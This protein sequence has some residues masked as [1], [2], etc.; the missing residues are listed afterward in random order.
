ME[1]IA[2]QLLDLDMSRVHGML[3]L[4]SR[5]DEWN[6]SVWPALHCFPFKL[7]NNNNNNLN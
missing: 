1:T 6:S 3:D 4:S 5:L 7:N 2:E